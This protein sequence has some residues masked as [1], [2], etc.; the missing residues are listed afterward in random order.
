MQSQHSFEFI[1]HQLLNFG[2]VHSASELHGMLS[3]LISVGGEPKQSEWPDMAREFLDLDEAEYNQEQVALFNQLLTDTS[4]DFSDQLLRF[5]PLL[6]AD[7]ADLAR[8]TEEL[9]AWC[10][11]FLH[12]AGRILGQNQEA[13]LASEVAEAVRDIAN[14]SQVTLDDDDNPEE[15]EGYWSE[16]V[17]YVKVAVLTIYSEYKKQP[18]DT[19]VH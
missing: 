2:A 6:P 17:E 1:N 15:S 14:I 8:R 7:D 4:E 16:L 12:G 3:G 19:T 18:Q 13:A 5:L 9:G 11:G 10:S